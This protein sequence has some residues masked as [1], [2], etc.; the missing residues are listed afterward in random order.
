M[1]CDNILAGTIR[2]SC[3]NGAFHEPDCCHAHLPI[4]HCI[5]LVSAVLKD[6]WSANDGTC[7]ITP[8]CYLERM[9]FSL[10]VA[11]LERACK[12]SSFTVKIRELTSHFLYDMIELVSTAC[13]VLY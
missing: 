4:F 11:T 9:N 6:M 1:G 13:N 10:K 8:Q 5:L 3:M 2:I 7:Y 12:N